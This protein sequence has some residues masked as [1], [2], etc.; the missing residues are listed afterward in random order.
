[1]NGKL[2][3]GNLNLQTTNENFQPCEKAFLFPSSIILIGKAI[4]IHKNFINF[5][6]RTNAKANIGDPP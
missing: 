4:R 1:M 2:F 5:A 3:V 6:F